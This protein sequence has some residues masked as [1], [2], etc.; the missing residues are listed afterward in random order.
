MILNLKNMSKG[1]NINNVQNASFGLKRIKGN[2]K[3]L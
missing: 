3:L 1:K 2:L